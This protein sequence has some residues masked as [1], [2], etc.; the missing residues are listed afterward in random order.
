MMSI[1]ND[2][3][4]ELNIFLKN[5]LK[6]NCQL[7]RTEMSLKCLQINSSWSQGEFSIERKM[8]KIKIFSKSLVLEFWI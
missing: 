5:M 3:L 1:I 6:I 8:I 7:R 2:T 4:K